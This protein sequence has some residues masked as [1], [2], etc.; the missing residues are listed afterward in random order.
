MA[1]IHSHQW[2]SPLK[3]IPNLL[4]YLTLSGL[5]GETLFQLRLNHNTVVNGLSTGLERILKI[6]HFDP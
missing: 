2:E 6:F 4:E 5:F 3:G 1:G